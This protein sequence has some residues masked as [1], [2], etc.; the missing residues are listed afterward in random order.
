MFDRAEHCGSATALS[1]R[2]L[3]LLTFVPRLR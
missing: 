3:E 2:L 1:Q